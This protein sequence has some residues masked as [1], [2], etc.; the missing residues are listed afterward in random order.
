MEKEQL[1]WRE[2]CENLGIPREVVL[3]FLEIFEN[4]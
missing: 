4:F 1:L 2:K 3:Y